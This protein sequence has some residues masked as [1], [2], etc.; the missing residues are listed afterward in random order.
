MTPE[1]RQQQAAAMRSSLSMMVEATD[2]HL[3]IRQL[4]AVA[5]LR[6]ETEL[7]NLPDERADD[8]DAAR[9]FERLSVA[10]RDVAATQWGAD[11]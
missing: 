8:T 1:Q 6:A 11:V 4:A 3:V 7:T 2:W 10:L 9:R 5:H